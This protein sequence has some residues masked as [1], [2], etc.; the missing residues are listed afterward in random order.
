MSDVNVKDW[1]LDARAVVK[2]NRKNSTTFVSAYCHL[3]YRGMTDY[4]NGPTT[5][6]Y[7]TATDL[8]WT[9]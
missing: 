6:L 1:K 5:E 8:F 2:L 9:R 7:S 3:F 4:R